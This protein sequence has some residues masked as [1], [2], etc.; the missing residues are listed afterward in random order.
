MR[1]VKTETGENKVEL[2]TI[3]NTLWALYFLGITVRKHVTETSPNDYV[4]KEAII[5]LVFKQFKND[6]IDPD[7]ITNI[8]SD[9]PS[10]YTRCKSQESPKSSLSMGHIQIIPLIQ[11]KKVWEHLQIF[12]LKENHQ[13]RSPMMKQMF[14]ES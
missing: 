14:P 13:E 6:I 8:I 10:I 2:W 12:P 9:A 7:G 1:K 11:K 5:D 4:G 3:R